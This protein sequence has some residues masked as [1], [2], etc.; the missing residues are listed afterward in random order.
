VV[1]AKPISSQL[2]V[3]WKTRK[4]KKL[5][6]FFSESNESIHLLSRFT[7]ESQFGDISVPFF[8]SV[9]PP[10]MFAGAGSMNYL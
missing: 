10:P 4:A 9:Y 5:T 7:R 3:L 6:I 2:N 1:F 8:V